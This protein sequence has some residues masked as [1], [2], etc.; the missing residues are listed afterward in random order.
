MWR[1]CNILQFLI[2][3][4]LAPSAAPAVLAADVACPAVTP[5]LPKGI[6]SIASSNRA[7]LDCR[8][9]LAPRIVDMAQL[10]KSNPVPTDVATIAN[11]FYDDSGW[12]LLS[13]TAREQRTSICR[14]QIDRFE[15]SF[16][17]YE[18]LA[19]RHDFCSFQ[20]Q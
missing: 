8:R 3:A 11:N 7:Q 14:R 17:A 12:P 1:W 15:Q 18:E 4:L 6:G 16:A 20:A 5:V 10:V 13:K 9:S 2:H 19:T